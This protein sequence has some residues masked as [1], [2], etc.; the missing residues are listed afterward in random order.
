MTSTACRHWPAVVA[1]L[2]ATF[3]LV[4]KQR[5]LWEVD[6]HPL[7]IVIKVVGNKRFGR[8]V[9]SVVNSV[10]FTKWCIRGEGLQTFGRNALSVVNS[11]LFSEVVYSR[12]KAPVVHAAARLLSRRSKLL[13]RRTLPADVHAA[14][15]TRQPPFPSL[16]GSTACGIGR[17]LKI[18]NRKHESRQCRDVEEGCEY[19]YIGFHTSPVARTKLPHPV[20]RTCSRCN[21]FAVDV[22]FSSYR[23]ATN[24]QG[25]ARVGRH[26]ELEEKSGKGM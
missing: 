7:S 1:C 14:T 10:L 24:P 15:V 19:C 22:M 13:D 17:M 21:E 4:S 8:N 20:Q 18:E 2:E 6:V 16:A 9:L 26:G 23:M 3:S 25:E 12:G 5:S 11:V